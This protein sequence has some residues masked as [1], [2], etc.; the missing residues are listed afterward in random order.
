MRLSDAMRGAAENAPI[1]DAT[2]STA[3]AARAVRRNRRLHG[4]ANG[5]V[6]VGAVAVVALGIGVPTSAGDTDSAMESSGSEATEESQMDT[7]AGDA[8]DGYR[9]E[10]LAGSGA[11]AMLAEQWMCGSEFAADDPAW[12]FGDASG[13]E[14]SVGDI[15]VDGNEYWVPETITAKRPVDLV[16]S[17]DYVIVWDG[18]VVGRLV[19]PS[20]VVYGP[21]DEPS[22]PAGEVYE[23]LDP[24]TEFGSVEQWI[25]LQ[26]VNCWDGAALP[27]GD[28]EVYLAHTLAYP[29]E[30][31]E[32]P[33]SAPSASPAPSPSAAASGA[34]ASSVPTED[35]AVE[36]DLPGTDLSHEL[37]RV[38]GGPVTLSVDGDKVDDPFGQY[39]SPAQPT[40]APEPGEPAPLPEPGLPDPLEPKPLPEGSLTPDIVRELFAADQASGAWDM[41]AG[42][43]RWVM[44]DATTG[45]YA[46]FGCTWGGQEGATFPSTTSTMDVLD[47]QVDVPRSL[48]VSYGFVVDGN[49]AITTT[50]TNVSEYDIQ[51]YWGST[52]PQLF[53]V[54]D[55]RVV[56]EGYPQDLGDT[57][58]RSADGAAE[59]LIWPAPESQSLAAGA[60][61][62]GTSLW[63]DVTR[64]DGE[65]GGEGVQSG[66]YTLLASSGLSVSNQHYEE[67]VRIMDDSAPDNL[68]LLDE[69][70]GATSLL[71]FGDTADAVEPG[72]AIDP[73]TTSEYEWVDLQ[74]WTSLGT[75]TVTAR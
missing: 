7:S 23:R 52:E 14:Y 66:T 39:L 48:S 75:V 8:A 29:A 54:R 73:V 2:V 4:A 18:L 51:D 36:E 3:A 11:D 28:Y 40:A 5:L 70:D 9:D 43:H 72:V 44:N 6:G 74:L 30:A 55:G 60:S 61:L 13:V 49:P 62:T 22:L 16:A 26:P 12:S 45:E 34:D 33:D 19:N 15:E 37:V 24:D 20:P 63:R 31:P 32:S 56:A 47:M 57:T 50:L 69:A 67:E 27:G 68:S 17:A 25:G 35:L 46:Y 65:S 42:T 1:E 21:A 41:A 71:P 38:A 10:G 53:L 58:A 64:C 59:A